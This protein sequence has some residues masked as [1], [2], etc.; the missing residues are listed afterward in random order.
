MDSA[1]KSRATAFV[2][3]MLQVTSIEIVI[4]YFG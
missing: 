1:I 2:F 3:K 4:A